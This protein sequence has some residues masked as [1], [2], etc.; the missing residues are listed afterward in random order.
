MGG[1]A[2]LMTLTGLVLARRSARALRPASA[3]ASA[4]TATTKKGR[5]LR[6][7]Q[8]DGK[9]EPAERAFDPIS[10]RYEGDAPHHAQTM[11]IAPVQRQSW[12]TDRPAVG[13]I[14]GAAPGE[15]VEVARH[16]GWPAPGQRRCPGC[17]EHLATNDA[18]CPRCGLRR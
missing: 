7:G 4:A 13:A 5:R 17:G 18:F 6:G 9:V 3:T 2:L 1:V 11:P 10:E 16:P 12:A 14:T 15:W 8:D